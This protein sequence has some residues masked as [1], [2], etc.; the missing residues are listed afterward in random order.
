MCHQLK[1][2]WYLLQMGTSK[3]AFHPA[4]E[5]VSL[6]YYFTTLLRYL[7]PM[8]TPKLAFHSACEV[9]KGLSGAC[10]KLVAGVWVC[11]CVGVYIYASRGLSVC[12]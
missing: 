1:T 6:L 12:A 3:F 10:S 7:L 5:L 2:V 11:W 4:S 9:V 8:G